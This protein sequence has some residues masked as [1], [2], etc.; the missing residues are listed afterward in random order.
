MYGT[1]PLSQGSLSPLLNTPDAQRYQVSPLHVDARAP[2][3]ARSPSGPYEDLQ[4]ARPDPTIQTPIFGPSTAYAATRVMSP[5]NQR[6]ITNNPFNVF[7]ESNNSL[8]L[9]FQTQCPFCNQMAPDPPICAQCGILGHAICIGLEHFQGFSFCRQCFNDV[10]QSYSLI[11][12]AALRNSWQVSTTQQ[13]MTW[14][15][16]ARNAIG[17]SASIGIAVGGAAA[18]V[19]GAVTGLAQGL[20]QGASSAM[21][22]QTAITPPPVPKED[23]SCVRPVSL[24]RAK[25]TEDIKW[26]IEAPCAKCEFGSRSA[27]TFTGSCRGLPASVYFGGKASSSAPVSA[28]ASQPI[29]NPA[30][31]TTQQEQD[32]E[33]PDAKLERLLAEKLASTPVPR[34]KAQPPD[35]FGSANSE[36]VRSYYVPRL[37]SPQGPGEDETIPEVVP[38]SSLTYSELTDQLKRVLDSYEEMTRAVKEL[39]MS[40]S[41]LEINVA[42]LQLQ[43]QQRDTEAQHFD[44]HTPRGDL[45]H[46]WYGD[47]DSQAHPPERATHLADQTVAA[48]SGPDQSAQIAAGTNLHSYPN[49][50]PQFQSYGQPAPDATASWPQARNSDGGSHIPGFQGS[51]ASPDSDVFSFLASAQPVR[52]ASIPP[53]SVG[54]N[55]SRAVHSVVSPLNQGCG[56]PTM[57]AGNAG[58]FSPPGLVVSDIASPATPSQAELGMILK[59]IQTF[60]TDFPKLELGDVATRA[61]RLISWKSSVSQ[62]LKPTGPQTHSWWLWILQKA[63]VAYQRFIKASIQD[64]ESIF[65]AD[66]LPTA[67]EQLDSWMRPKLL[68]AIPAQIRDWVNSRTRLGCVDGSHVITFLCSEAIRAG[69]CR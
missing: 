45:L 3:Y 67:W 39:Q 59:G 44:V 34:P 12:D 35:S 50:L 30:Q 60:L 26:K 23:S 29:P 54:V 15:E 8:L 32:G 64:R 69:K 47:P 31:E 62:A 41:N 6:M 19:A 25:S 11:N 18:T 20:V 51:Q 33:R 10:M 56:I 5:N 17:T 49:N 43:L 28:S 66:L 24:R 9:G 1:A 13:I 2:H 65:P 68:E 7:P 52:F 48:R 57:P 58:V 40:V 4:I 61:T 16:H 63:M 21:S 55:N 36:Q 46:Q 38:D 14:K 37:N 27:H 42:D 22:G 53:E